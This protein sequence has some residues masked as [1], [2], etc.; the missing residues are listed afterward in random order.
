MSKP[1]VTGEILFP[2]HSV[3]PNNALAYVHLLDTS[4]ADAPSIIIAEE[5]IEDIAGKAARGERIRFAI[6]GEIQNQRASYSV[7]VH[8][9]VDRD[10]RVGAGDYINMQNY[11]V[12]T[13]GYPNH[14]EV[15][16]V[17]VK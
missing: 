15:K 13:F 8:I 9:D 5:V 4:L 11:P 12:I 16:V 14:I 1:L 7:S 6:Y 3:L 2:A 10:G 17:R